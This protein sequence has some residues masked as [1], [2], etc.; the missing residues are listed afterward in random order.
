MNHGVDRS[1]ASHF[2]EVLSHGLLPWGFAVL[3][4][5]RTAG[6]QK[7]CSKRKKTEASNPLRPGL[8][9]PMTLTVL[10]SIAQSTDW[11]SYDS[12][13]RGTKQTRTVR[14][15]RIA[16][17]FGDHPLQKCSPGICG[18][19]TQMAYP[20]PTAGQSRMEAEKAGGSLGLC[21]RC[22]GSAEGRGSAESWG[23]RGSATISPWDSPSA[24]LQISCSIEIDSSYLRGLLWGLN[25]LICIKCFYFKS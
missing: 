13:G 24:S 20:R 16:A 5:S 18:I 23:H 22:R 4:P 14:E 17:L 11:V 8:R 15:G 7:E 19:N 12:K 2:T 6:L 9:G 21:L 1:L 25:Y 10:L 3:P